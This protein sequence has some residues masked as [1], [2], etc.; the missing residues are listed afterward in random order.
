[1]AQ[2]LVELGVSADQLGNRRR[3]VRRQQRRSRLCRSSVRAGVLIRQNADLADELIAASGDGADQLAL[4]PVI[5]SNP[6]PGAGG[7]GDRAVRRAQ[8]PRR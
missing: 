4:R 8:K 3:Q 7:T 1:V 6:D 5:A 2:D